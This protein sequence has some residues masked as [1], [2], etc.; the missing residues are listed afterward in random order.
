M[1][2]K[3]TIYTTLQE[4]YNTYLL[5]HARVRGCITYV[6]WHAHARGGVTDVSCPAHASGGITDVFCY[7]HA[8]GEVTHMCYALGYHEW[9]FAAPVDV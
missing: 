1:Q 7:A 6:L 2:L 3:H 8:R 9:F 4:Y 5:C